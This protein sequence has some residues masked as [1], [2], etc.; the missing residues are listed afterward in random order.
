RAE[1]KSRED[2]RSRAQQAPR[3]REVASV[4]S[5][6]PQSDER[7]PERL[8]GTRVEE[9][10][11]TEEESDLTGREDCLE[12]DARFGKR[13]TAKARGE[14]EGDDRRREKSAVQETEDHEVDGE[15]DGARQEARGADA[16]G[17]LGL[18]L[19]RRIVETPAELGSVRARIGAPR[20]RL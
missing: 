17:A 11:V 14:A 3:H 10:E 1:R 8:S 12:E 9:P 2:V 20:R 19:E 13:A 5:D 7:L 4:A 15:G 6:H 18:G 16:R